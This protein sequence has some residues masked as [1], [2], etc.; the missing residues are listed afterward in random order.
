MTATVVIVDDHDG[1]RTTARAVLGGDG[2]EIVGEA[3]DG[4]AGIEAVLALAP[5]VVLLDIDLPDLDGFAVA[6]R[7]AAAGSTAVVVLTSSRDRS[8]FGPLL[9]A[10]S[11]RG[12]IAKAELCGDT[13]RS[14][15]A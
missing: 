1:F 15:T 9:D 11:V 4:R 14:A 8:D 13:L 6:E 7:L 12:F 10:A 2:F 5:D 3:A